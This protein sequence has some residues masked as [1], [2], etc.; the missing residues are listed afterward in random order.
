MLSSEG[1]STGR[2]ALA[3]SHKL[4]RLD[5][6]SAMRQQEMALITIPAV[7]TAM[8]LDGW[9]RG[10]R[11]GERDGGCYRRSNLQHNPGVEVAP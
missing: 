7:V 2:P 10:R 11:M 9:V 4:S 5:D 8:L 1:F 3:V 6:L